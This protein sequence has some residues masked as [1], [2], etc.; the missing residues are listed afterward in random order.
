VTAAAKNKIYG[1]VDPAFTY[2][3]TGSLAFSDV[4]AGN[5]TRVTGENVGAYAIQQGT[6]SLSSNYNL[7][8]VENNLT[9]SNRPLTITVNNKTKLYGSDIPV[10]DGIESGIIASDNITVSY[11]TTATAASTIGV[12]P[13]TATVNDPD[14]RL[15]NY[16]VT[17][18]PGT[19]TITVV[20][21]I[22]A[23]TTSVPNV[24]YSDK[25]TFT[26][27]I[28][29][30]APVVTDANGAAVS[31]TFKVGNQV[32]GT[33]PLTVS[34]SGNDLVGVLADQQMVEGLAGQMA[35]GAKSVTA[36]FNTP[37]AN[38]GLSNS[39]NTK[40]C[41]LTII[42]EDA[43]ITYTGQDYISLPSTTATSVTVSL[44]ATIRDL[45]DGN[46]G[47]IKNA[48]V[49]FRKDNPVTGAVL[50][51][52][53]LTPA[54]MTDSTVGTVVTSFVCSLNA[55]ELGCGGANLQVYAVVDYYYTGGTSDVATTITIA[56]PGSD[57]VTGGGFLRNT[58]CAGAIA[59]T[60]GVKTNFGFNM[61]YNKSG[62]NLKGQCNIIIRS[63][64]RIYQVKS[65]AVNTLVVSNSNSSGTPAYF[66]TKAN[67]TD[68]T[69]PLSPV[70]LGGNM[71]LTVKMNDVSAGGQGD[72]TSILL[73]NPNTSQVIFSSNWSGVQTVLQTLGGG[74]VSV[75]STPS[76]TTVTSA[77]TEQS[78]EIAAV[79]NPFMVKV[80][81]NPAQDH[82]TINIQGSAGKIRLRVIDVQGRVVES[83]EN[84]P[85]G[86]LQLGQS[87]RSGFYYLEV[88]QGN[89]MRQI[90]L[91]KL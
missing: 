2:Q 54:M 76:T 50:G 42:P 80:L 67:C 48:R 47:N 13:I 14:S 56:R 39:N 59:G 44:S 35:P 23:V 53:N 86:S 60:P 4:F 22:T 32:M 41:P 55:T 24:Q 45:L 75:R 81:G 83:R 72:Q 9:I 58:A 61:Q 38:Y 37:N 51:T 66:N 69:N 10:L 64:G 78:E 27:T 74:N 70:S 90:K 31:V 63:N 40:T 62:S 68:I 36:I 1:N 65:N 17:N 77:R 20:P 12:Y 52:P 82:F 18:T 49:T 43:E 19:L 85:E 73:M 28:S 34:V 16:T 11:S 79:V 26:A 21:V 29:G 8:Y 57:F 30:G 3:V 46:R 25:V 91:V 89:N 84:V 71:D 6:L 33:V 15:F 5:L 88:R 7:S 87:Y